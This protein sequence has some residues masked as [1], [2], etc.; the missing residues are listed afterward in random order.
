MKYLIQSILSITSFVCIVNTSFGQENKERNDFAYSNR[1]S[2]LA[3]LIQPMVLDGGNIEVTYF[4]KRMS[5]DYS[6][7][8][9]LNMS[10]GTMVGDAKDQQLAYHLP[11]STG[12]GIGYRLTSSFDIRIEP[13]WHKWEVYYDGESQ[14][15]NTMIKSYSTY[16]LGLGAYYRY[17]PFSK[18]D[19]WLQGITTSTSVRWWPNIGSSLE[20]NEFTY[21]NKFTNQD[22]TLKASNIG[23]AGTQFLFNISLGY[24]FGGK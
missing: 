19:N 24:T 20:N 6:H 18:K 11:F 4:S 8:F 17:M 13:K 5:F 22:E 2:V 3:G 9:L 15:E 10:G 16:T 21:H 14:N 23:I 12:F 1:F 7:G